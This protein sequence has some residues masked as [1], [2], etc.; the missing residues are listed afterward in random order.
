MRTQP[1]GSVTSVEKGPPQQ[2]VWG[3]DSTSKHRGGLSRSSHTCL[4]LRGFNNHF[5]T[6]F[7]TWKKAQCDATSQCA[8]HTHEILTYRRALLCP[9]TTVPTRGK[10]PNP[11]GSVSPESHP[12]GTCNHNTNSG[13]TPLHEAKTIGLGCMSPSRAPT[14]K[15]SLWALS[16]SRILWPPPMSSSM[17]WWIF[18]REELNCSDSSMGMVVS[19]SC[20][21]NAGT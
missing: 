21:R 9:G 7:S 13:T 5:S 3:R 16:P 2:A 14:F 18:W 6:K 17:P 11:W 10:E 4:L 19:E 8:T 15:V 20:E 1:R 12:L